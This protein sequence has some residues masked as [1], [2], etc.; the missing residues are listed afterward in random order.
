MH[1]PMS[2]H[3]LVQDELDQRSETGYDVAAERA[4]FEET[5][6]E[7][8]DRFELIFA[9]ISEARRRPGWDY[10]EPEGLEDIVDS[11]PDP[12][13]IVTPTESVVEEK[14]L[15]GWLGRIAGCNLGK[16][17]EFG[18]HWTSEHLRDYLELADAWPLRDYI[19]ILDPLPDGFVF[20]ENWGE[21]T[22][23]R[24]NGS[25][26]DDDIDYPILGLHLLEEHGSALATRHVADA[27]LTLLPYFQV[28]TAERAAYKNL[29]NGVPLER[30]PIVR[31]PYREWIGALIRGDVF[32]WT[33]PGPPAGCIAF[34]YRDAAPLPCRQRGIRRTMVGRARRRRVQ[35]RHRPRRR[36]K[37]SLD[38][39][40][41]RSRLAEALRFVA[42]LPLR[43][44]QLGP[45]DHGD[46]GPL[47]PLQL[48]AH[49][50][51]RRC[52][53]RRGCS[54]VRMTTRPPSGSRFRAG[55]TQTRTARRQGSVAGVVLGA[56][57]AARAVHR[58]VARPHAPP[59]CSDSTTPGSRTWPVARRFWRGTDWGN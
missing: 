45:G 22:R 16:P 15:G 40:P 34:A 1:E 54:G 5:D 27:W 17:V 55:G 57:C 8:G 42:G 41:P 59:R 12:A 14:I 28:Y 23:G 21:T 35:R 4:A 48:G 25:A 36:S 31:N 20:R 2:S 50:Q 44:S 47:R 51:Q 9:S 56:R 19:P 49:H 38:H 24:V 39:V 46:P 13:P 29:L 6:P 30:V 58:A 18:P 43:R 26:R 3:D 33:N 52:Q 37:A 11:L 32:G 53:S 7:D 10:E